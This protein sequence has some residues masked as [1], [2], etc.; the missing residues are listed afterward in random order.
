[1]AIEHT[2]LKFVVSPETGETIGFVSRPWQ[3]NKLKGVRENSIF[4]KKICVLADDLKGKILPDIPY[5]V[6]LK[7]MHSGKGY[8][9]VRATPKLF[10]AVV[11]TTV[12]SKSIYQ[13]TVHFGNKTVYFDPKDGNKSSSRTIKG[14]VELLNDRTDI[15][16]KELVIKEFKRQ[17]FSL[18]R[19]MQVEGYVFSANV[20]GLE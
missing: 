1:M 16:N 17:A 10:P 12:I 15:E 11:E 4:G 8:V 5:M 14:V 6:E 19:C 7:P 3:S 2:Q 9:V 20:T 18:V 13:V